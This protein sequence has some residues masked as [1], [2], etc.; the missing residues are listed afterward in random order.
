MLAG[1][2]GGR[3]ID[4]RVAVKEVGSLELEADVFH[5]HNWEV[6]H[7][8]SVRNAKAVPNDRVIACHWPILRFPK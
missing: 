3:D 2:D 6:L 8:D 7:P 1:T 5:W 4:S